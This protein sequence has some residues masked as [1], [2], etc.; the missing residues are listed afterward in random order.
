MP[1]MTASVP[2]QDLLTGVDVVALRGDPTIEIND[3]AYD[4]RRVRPGS[5]FACVVGTRDDGHAHAPAA[6]AAGA[7]ALLVERPLDEVTI[8]GVT[9]ARVLDVR[10]ALGPAAAALHGHPSRSLR[11][12]GITGT[13]G[14]I[15]RAHV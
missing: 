12:F 11:C 8:G 5:C 2:L 7:V 9:E 4:S 13:N 1:E 10:R 15:G 14:K 6:V 3:L